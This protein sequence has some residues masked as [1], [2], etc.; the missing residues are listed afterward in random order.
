MK[1]LLLFMLA[2]VALVSCSDEPEDKT[3]HVNNSNLAGE[4]VYDHPE[5]NIWEVIKFQPSGIYY[6]WNKVSSA[7][8]KFQNEANY[9]RYTIEDNNK[10]ICHHTINGFAVE[11]KMTMLSISDYAFSAEFNDGASLGI[12]DYARVIDKKM[13]KP[14]EAFTPNYKAL[15]KVDIKGYKSH[16]TAIATV[17][18]TSGEIKG[19]KPGF[20]YIDVETAEGT[21]AIEI[22]VFDPENP[23]VDYSFALGKTIP[24]LVE[25][26]GDNYEYRNDKNGLVYT[27]DDYLCDTV[28]FITGI[29]DYNHVEFIQHFFNNRLSAEEINDHLKSKY[30]FLA[31]GED[32]EA[33]I[34][35]LTDAE[36]NPILYS[37]D[38]KKSILSIYVLLPSD[39][40]TDFSFLF[41]M[42]KSVVA[43]EMAERKYNFIISDY[44]YSAN[45]SDYYQMNDSYDANLV[46]FVFNGEEK[47][48]DYW[49]Y[50]T[51]AGLKNKKAICTWLESRYTLASDESTK[52]QY[53]Y[54]DK[55]KRMRIVFD[56]SGYVSY[57]DSEQTPFIPASTN[58]PAKVV[59]P[60]INEQQTNASRISIR[61]PKKI[62]M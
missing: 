6:Y 49:V 50:L 5:L 38:K 21:A 33:Y 4:W 29:Y 45:G 12:I 13:I 56:L 32:Y 31:S 25:I 26:L 41:G 52:N 55:T 10:I 17:D 39:R 20:T 7:D 44:S 14:G 27:T 42:S 28:K 23:I 2:C 24:E 8:W 16:N 51:N 62:G 35:D 36:G 58:M 37:F 18:P 59:A 47:M 57:T 54:Y 19:V 1:K 48:C 46:G 53:V 3:V 22:T 30:T 43:N 9:G 40:W 60:Q 11:I 15:V 61:F 34:S